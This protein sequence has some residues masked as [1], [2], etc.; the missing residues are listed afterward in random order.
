M[1][2]SLKPSKQNFPEKV[3][4][5]LIFPNNAMKIL[6][7]TAAFLLLLSACGLNRLVY[8]SPVDDWK[9]QRD[10]LAN[11]LVFSHSA[12]NNGLISSGNFLGYEIFYKFYPDNGAVTGA[13][14]ADRTY[15]YERFIASEAAITAQG[16]QPLYRTT[17]AGGGM[18]ANPLQ[19]PGRPFLPVSSAGTYT[20]VINFPTGAGTG[21]NNIWGNPI[22]T[23]ATQRDQPVL[24]IFA[25]DPSVY[26]ANPSLIP[27][28][29]FYL[30]RI[31]NTTQNNYR[32]SFL[33]RLGT[34]AETIPAV[35][36]APP[37]TINYGY[38]VSGDP[39]LQRLSGYTPGNNLC[40]GICVVAYG[41]DDNFSPIYSEAVV[42]NAGP[43]Y[44]IYVQF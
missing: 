1:L 35:P 33:P 11:G 9:V 10:G 20:Y 32:K 4:R 7:V 5:K 28:D 2:R 25:G 38:Y 31:L 22:P 21:L 18:P 27:L 40:V 6:F 16:F 41:R 42:I 23:Q 29:F 15:F 24:R 19:R 43:G 17:G 30:Y 13:I 26:L 39:D 44:G 12:G 34:S 3:V 37:E 8:L 14:E 36:P